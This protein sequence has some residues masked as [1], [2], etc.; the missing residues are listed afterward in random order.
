MICW[1]VG[2]LAYGPSFPFNR[3]SR[4]TTVFLFFLFLSRGGGGGISKWVFPTGSTVARVLSSLLKQFKSEN[5]K[6]PYLSPGIT[7]SSCGSLKTTGSPAIARA[8]SCKHACGPRPQ[9]TS[10][11]K[12]SPSTLTTAVTVTGK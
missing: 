2:T 6:L 8:T 4:S 5:A 7:L 3:T 1:D 10:C 12:T 11:T 9:G